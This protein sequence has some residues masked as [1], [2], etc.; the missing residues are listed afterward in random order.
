MNDIIKK[1]EDCLS[2]TNYDLK[3]DWLSVEER[4]M[5]ILDSIRLENAIASLKALSELN[6]NI[7]R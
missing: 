6:N 5:Y 1:L 4:T 2:D 3:Q 7:P